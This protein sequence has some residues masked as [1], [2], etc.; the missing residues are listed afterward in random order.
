MT[1]E[2]EAR[3]L[4]VLQQRQ[5]DMTLITERVHKP[6]NIAALIRNCDA[7]GIAK[8]HYVVPKEGYDRLNGTS[9][10]SDQWVETRAYQTVSDAVSA[11]KREG[12]NVFAAHLSSQSVDFRDIDYTQPFALMMGAEKEGISPLGAEL[13]DRHIAI[14]MMGMVESFN[15]STAAGIIL[16]EAQRQRLKAGMYERE[17]LPVMQKARILFEA[18]NPKIAR[19]YR[20]SG[21]PYPKYD[22]Q[23]FLLDPDE[24]HQVVAKGRALA[25][26]DKKI[27]RQTRKRAKAHR[28]GAH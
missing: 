26:Q 24:T 3:L 2:R 11:V 13:A 25:I 9:M 27:S 1:P 14:P 20:L 10:G 16:V 17:G 21:Q 7:V 23:G 22:A 15:V 6:R 8:M 5:P 18:R 28:L 19:Y 4:S 12:M